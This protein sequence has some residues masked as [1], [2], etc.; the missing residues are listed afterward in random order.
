MA[1]A[2]LLYG[3]PCEYRVLKCMEMFSQESST[4]SALRERMDD[5]K[6]QLERCQKEYDRVR[7]EEF[8][9][10]VKRFLDEF[11]IRTI[12]DLNKAAM[13]LRGMNPDIVKEAARNIRAQEAAPVAAHEAPKQEAPYETYYKPSKEPARVSRKTSSERVEKLAE[14]VKSILPEH[15]IRKD[16]PAHKEAASEEKV[17]VFFDEKDLPD[18]TPAEGKPTKEPEEAVQE[19]FTVDAIVPEGASDAEPYADAEVHHEEAKEPVTEAK[20]PADSFTAEESFDLGDDEIDMNWDFGD[21]NGDV[22]EVE[23]APVDEVPVK[24]VPSDVPPMSDDEINAL[25]DK[26]GKV[27]LSDEQVAALRN[28][29]VVV[30]AANKLSHALLIANQELDPSMPMKDVSML[31]DYDP[32]AMKDTSIREKYQEADKM[33]AVL[34]EN[35]SE[36]NT[37]KAYA[38]Y[39]E[40]KDFPDFIRN[41]AMTL[42]AME[43]E[44]YFS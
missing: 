32:A 8:K 41:R 17:E 20:K 29:V 23:E 36:K 19:P 33:I 42:V 1:V 39:A 35:I 15:M 44:E 30:R 7:Q 21:E 28:K 24:K 22:Q 12:E 3:E 10:A 4:L 37:P 26:I 14:D 25:A 11:N 43:I 38:S 40:F 2:H 18:L 27:S 31:F 5:L 16:V 34:D 6:A 13:K 9:E